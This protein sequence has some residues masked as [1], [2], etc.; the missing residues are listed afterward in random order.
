MFTNVI[1]I[2]DFKANIENPNWVI[3][4]CR[5]SLADKESGR[6]DYLNA[7]IPGARYAHLD[8]DLS[9]E[10][11]AGTTGRHPLP[12]VEKAM[13]LFTA[14]GIGEETQVIVYDQFHGGIA[15]RLW[16]MLKW[17]GH[18]K[19]AVLEGGWKAWKASGLASENTIQ[20]PM[21]KRFEPKPNSDMIRHVNVLF[22]NLSEAKYK[23]IDSRGAERY[24]GTNEPI[25]PIAGHVPGAIS[26]PFIENI[27]T[28]GRFLPKSILKRRFEEL[29]DGKPA[30]E[31]IFYCGSGVT[32][33][34]N[35]LAM[36]Y[37]GLESALLYP[38]SWSDWITDGE[39]PIAT[40]K[41]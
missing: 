40:D 16:W 1:S 13:A 23:V 18:N 10:I 30:S 11:I 20:T 37:A 24:A 12:S 5:F 17:L 22:E 32:A 7:H 15:A 3:I 28:E 4:D 19:V 36:E 29:L 6:R 35:L 8:N 33:C 41:E 38:G 9:G 21:A 14:W 27:D 31:T 34:H 2:G 25:D 39:R 26:A